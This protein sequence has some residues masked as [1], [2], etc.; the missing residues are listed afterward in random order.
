MWVQR[1]VN[2]EHLARGYHLITDR[3]VQS[4][5]QILTRDSGAIHILSL[6]DTGNDS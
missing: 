5:Y 4:I 2:L 6:A 3:V 1:T